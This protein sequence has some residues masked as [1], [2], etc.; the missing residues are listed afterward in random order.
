MVLGTEGLQPGQVLIGEQVAIGVIGVVLQ[1]APV[2]VVV[3]AREVAGVVVQLTPVVFWQPRGWDMGAVGLAAGSGFIQVSCRGCSLSLPP[4]QLRVRTG[5]RGGRLGL[6][7]VSGQGDRG[8]LE[9]LG[10]HLVV[11]LG[12]AEPGLAGGA[13]LV[14]RS[15]RSAAA[16]PVVVGRRLCRARCTTVLELRWP[17]TDDRVVGCQGRMAPGAVC[18]GAGSMAW[19]R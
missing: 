9:H 11:G 15:R 8:G 2:L 7:V 19:P 10:G 14:R 1:L 6:A 4:C 17:V 18:G 3:N 5:G 13:G 16:S 12:V